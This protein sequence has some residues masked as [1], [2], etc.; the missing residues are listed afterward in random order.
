MTQ[1]IIKGTNDPKD[2]VKRQKKDI[3]LNMIKDSM[4]SK[5]KRK[6]SHDNG[7][8]NN[9]CVKQGNCLTC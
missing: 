9:S 3:W 8:S 5:D 6:K 7:L 4:A 1:F 2:V